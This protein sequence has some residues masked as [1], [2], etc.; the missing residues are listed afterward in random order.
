M[1]LYKLLEVRKSTRIGECLFGE[2][3]RGGKL[4]RF[5]GREGVKASEEEEGGPRMGTA[6]EVG[7]GS[8]RRTQSLDYQTLWSGL[9]MLYMARRRVSLEL[10]PPPSSTATAEAAHSAVACT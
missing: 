6:W 7:S 10:R 9:A 3:E 8:G 1:E 4:R 5:E 2:E